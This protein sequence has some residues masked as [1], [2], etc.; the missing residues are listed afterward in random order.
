MITVSSP[1]GDFDAQNSIFPYKA[2]VADVVSYSFIYFL[3]FLGSG[4]G[5]DF[6][7][8]YHLHFNESLVLV[9]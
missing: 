5:R 2:I 8:K 6:H 1:A 9:V 4:T 3:S 7:C